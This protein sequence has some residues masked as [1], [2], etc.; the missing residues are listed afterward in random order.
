MRSL[1][2]LGSTG[3]I[4]VYTLEIASKYPDKFRVVSLAAGKNVEKLREQIRKFHPSHVSISDASMLGLLKSEFPKVKFGTEIE[5]IRA[6]ISE[7]DVDVVVNGIVGFAGLE[8]A[9]HAIREDKL[10]AIANKESFVVAG[11][12]LNE[13]LAKSKATL[14]PVDSEHNAL[15]Q[16]IEGRS[17]SDIET[18]V[19]TA[20]GGPFLRRTDLSFD[21]VTP[22]MA[23]KHPKWNMGPKISVDSATLMNKG[24]ELVEAHYLF[25]FP[26]EKIE[27]WIHP[28]SIVHGA[29]WLKDGSCLAQMTVPDMK[30]SIGYAVAYPKKL[31]KVIPRF[32]FKEI[33]Q[34]EF[35]EPDQERFTALKI[36]RQA[37]RAG[38]SALVTLNAANEVAVGAFLEKRIK[39]SQITQVVDAALQK[40]KVV[41]PTSLAE[42]LELDRNSRDTTEAII[43]G[44]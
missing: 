19:L 23:I 4:G 25:G 26:E 10:L 17:K 11:E 21:D 33:A 5:G 16:L 32:S 35:I 34:L 13:E 9:I 24:L 8:P 40:E 36:V 30:S 27:I 6:C 3:T 22:E 7:P 43:K 14:I 29:I 1:C 28:Q 2:V 37:L 44:R 12:L 39:F 20:S 31:D 42:I 41:K 18:L 15:F 38:G